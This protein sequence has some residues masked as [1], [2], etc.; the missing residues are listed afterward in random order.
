[1]RV[2]GRGLP[3]AFLAVSGGEDR[4]RGALCAS[5]VVPS[6]ARGRR[7][8]REGHG[9][10]QNAPRYLRGTRAPAVSAVIKPRQSREEP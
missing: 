4:G 10:T 2:E 8:P 1:M 9:K 3:P 5:M 6:R 7:R